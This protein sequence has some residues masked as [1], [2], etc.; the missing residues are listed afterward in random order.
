MRLLAVFLILIGIRSLAVN[1]A[2]E[3]WFWNPPEGYQKAMDDVSRRSFVVG[4][5]F[6]IGLWTLRL[7]ALFLTAAVPIWMGLEVW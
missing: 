3:L 4:A 6:S 1:I 2:S 7:A 5:A